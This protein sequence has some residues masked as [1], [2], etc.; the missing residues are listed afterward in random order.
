MAEDGLKSRAHRLPKTLFEKQAL[1][2]GIPIIFRPTSKDNYKSVLTSALQELKKKG[3]EMGVYGDI[4][5][6]QH[7]KWIKQVGST[8]K[9]EPF[10][11]LWLMERR[12][13][14]NE[15][16]SLGF[17]ATII[18][19]KQDVMGTSFLGRTLNTKVLDEMEKSGIDASGEGGEFHT[20][21]IDGPI[22]SSSIQLETHETIFING[23]AYLNV[24]AKEG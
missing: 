12:S 7:L 21:V 19:V 23:Y 6:E 18:A 11:P 14:V 4:D 17:K 10:E 15:F 8:A 16:L 2:L 9:I 3:V 5:L 20:V 1:S 13:V 22:F 24:T